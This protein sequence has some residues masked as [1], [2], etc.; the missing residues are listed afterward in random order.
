MQLRW[1]SVPVGVAVVSVHVVAAAVLLR[2]AAALLGIVATLLGIVAALLGIAD[3]APSSHHPQWTARCD[4]PDGQRH[5]VVF[6][7]IVYRLLKAPWAVS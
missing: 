1:N 7:P 6:L 4:F 3:V 2:I 5:Q